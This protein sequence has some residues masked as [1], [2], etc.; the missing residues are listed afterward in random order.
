MKTRLKYI[1][2][3]LAVF[4]ATTACEDKLDIPQKGVL[5]YETY[6]NTDEEAETAATAL[7][8]EL[9]GMDFNYRLSKNMLGDDFWAGGGQHGDNADLDQLNE[10]T[11]STDQ[12]YIQ[13]MFQSYYNMIYKANVVL[14]HVPEETDVQKRVRAEAKVFRAFAYF[15][16]IS[17]WGN[18]PLVDHEL[19]P[20]EY[21]QPNGSTEELWGLVEQD[22][23]EAIGSG[24]LA[25]KSGVNDDTTWRITKQFAQALLGKTY[26]WQ[27]KYAEAA[28]ALNEVVNSGLYKL[29]DG[30]YSNILSIR[31]KFNTES[32]LES[33]RVIDLN[34]AWNNMS[35]TAIMIHWRTDKMNI[36]SEFQATGWGFCT[37]Q[38]ALYDA[39][40]AEEGENGYRLTQTMK[41]VEQMADLGNTIK[42]GSTM[43][44]EGYF[45][46]KTRILVE[47]ATPG[48]YEFTNGNNIR[49]M[50]YAEVLL[51]AAEANLQSG[52]QSKAAECLNEVR[53]RAKLSPKTNI[54]LQD[55]ITEKRLEL[56]GECTR[57]QDMVRWGIAADLL[58]NQGEKYPILDSNGHVTY[59]SEN[60]AGKYGFQEKHKLLPYPGTE[61]RLNPNINQ[62]PGW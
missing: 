34:N 27:S 6:Y 21:S 42:T 44:S 3:L 59:K 39:F 25:Q 1:S 15:D 10:F 23:T 14:G 4:M 62:N 51:L 41:T 40:V 60:S 19:E 28:S 11:F 38:K 57:F 20:S 55:I 2:I 13:G 18:P 9:L 45:M 53:S 50:R 12:S 16:L 5:N 52:N 54:S 46:W 33:N 49:W 56:C 47:E 43:I 32:V 48:T 7:Y 26:L 22:L 35:M 29:Y 36:T 61:M 37:P 31:T 24:Y 17:L 8:I 30:D 58:K